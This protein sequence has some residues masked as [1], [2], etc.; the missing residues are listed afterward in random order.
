[1]SYLKV[2]S[3]H[4]IAK[5]DDAGWHTRCGITVTTESVPASDTLPLGEKSCETCLRLEVVDTDRQNPTDEAVP[6]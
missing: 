3:W 4:R 5:V 6:A 2:R 1:M